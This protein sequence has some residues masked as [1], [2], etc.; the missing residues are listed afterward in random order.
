MKKINPYYKEY[1]NIEETHIRLKTDIENNKLKNFI[2]KTREDLKNYI[3]INPY[4]KTSLEKVNINNSNN[5][6][7]KNNNDYKNLNFLNYESNSKNKF[8]EIIRLMC[9]SS[10]ISE[11]G[12]MASVAG[13]ISELSLNYLIKKGTKYSIIENGG[14]IALINNKKLICGI[15]SNNKILKN[16][17]GFKIKEN[18]KPIGICTSS[19]KIGH[20]IS[21]GDSES[22]TVISNSAS[23]S[24]GLATRIAN[25]VCG[26]NSEDSVINALETCEKYKDYLKGVLIISGESIGRFGKLPK[27]IETP[28]FKQNII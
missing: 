7:D 19:G 5:N 28:D 4:F 20:S 2:Y 21:F 16:R 9:E 27:I 8:P 25:D 12:P 6:F 3:E 14:D 1:I 23:I 18:K 17:I 11:T 13:S 15:Y 24:D 22:V 26:N 10:N